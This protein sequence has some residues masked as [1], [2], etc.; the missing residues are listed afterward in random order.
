MGTKKR[1]FFSKRW[2]AVMLVVCVAAG[3]RLLA[4]GGGITRII[5]KRI[6][7]FPTAT[8]TKRCSKFQVGYHL[9]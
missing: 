8:Y 1:R 7:R 9:I 6:G 4:C 2:V 3:G 5:T